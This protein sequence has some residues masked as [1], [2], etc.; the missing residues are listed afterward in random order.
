MVT[1]VVHTLFS[2]ATTPGFRI[3]SLPGPCT[4]NRGGALIQGASTH[5]LPVP[6]PH[7]VTLP[8]DVVTLSVSPH[9]PLPGTVYP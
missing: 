1:R 8:F 5:M 4:V 9:P 3:P 2:S 7:L 6:L